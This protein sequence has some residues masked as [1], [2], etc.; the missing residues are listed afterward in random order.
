MKVT[1]WQWVSRMFARLV[2]STE[3]RLL[4]LIDDLRMGR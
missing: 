1:V 4:L 2:M 3:L